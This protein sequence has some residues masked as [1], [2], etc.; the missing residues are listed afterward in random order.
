MLAIQDSS[1][2]TRY[3]SVGSRSAGNAVSVVPL[4]SP[5]RGR[6]VLLRACRATTVPECFRWILN[7]EELPVWRVYVWRVMV[8]CGWAGVRE[9]S[10]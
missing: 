9:H 7:L 4:F 8:W 5:R 2:T 6:W 3:T 1:L 10:R